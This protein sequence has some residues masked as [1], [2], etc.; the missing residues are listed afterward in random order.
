[1]EIGD[2]NGCCSRR[3][4]KESTTNLGDLL[5]LQMN[6]PR[7]SFTGLTL[8]DVLGRPP[9]LLDVIRED[10]P[11]KKN[12]KNWSWK[13]FTEKP[14]SSKINEEL[15]P[16]LPSNQLAKPEVGKSLMELMEG[17]E[18]EEENG[19]RLPEVGMPLMVLL[20]DTQPEM[21]LE[22]LIQDE[23]E[24]EEEEEMEEVELNKWCCVCMVRQKGAA[25]IPCGHAFCRLCSRELWV[26]R[27]T[28]PLC[29]VF[30]LEILHIF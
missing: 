21:E 19:Q 11:N 1:M 3:L 20:A 5:L 18:D 2:G 12:K 24:E 29:N 30:I 8:N 6:G 7:N 10:D 22:G 28:C 27:G 17:E 16:P 14:R 9:P 26:K 13:S 15:N 4:E 25:F 23:E